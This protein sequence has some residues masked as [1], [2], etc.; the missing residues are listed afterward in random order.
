LHRSCSSPRSSHSLSHGSSSA[1]KAQT[2]DLS[3][4]DPPSEPDAESPSEPDV[5]LYEIAVGASHVRD[6][7]LVDALREE[8]AENI[9]FVVVRSPFVARDRHDV[10]LN[11]CLWRFLFFGCSDCRRV[12]FGALLRVLSYRCVCYKLF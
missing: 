12:D 5:V 1:A 7:L 6:V 3:R 9:K 8:L 10:N 11:L 2:F 4:N